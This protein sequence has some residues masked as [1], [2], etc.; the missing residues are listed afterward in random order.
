MSTSREDSGAARSPE[1]TILQLEERYPRHTPAK[2]DAIRREL[3][4][5][6]ARYYQLLGRL[7][8]NAHAV[9]LDPIAVHRLRRRRDARRARGRARRAA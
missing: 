8:D 2:E 5:S 3:A 4:I 1:L 6:P 7:L 9:T